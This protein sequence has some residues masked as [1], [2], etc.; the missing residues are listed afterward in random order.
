VPADGRQAPDAAGAS[1]ASPAA[2]AAGPAAGT[3]AGG[4]RPI[5]GPPPA[6]SVQDLSV[7]Y[8]T[9]FERVPTLK[10]AVVRL[11]RGERAV[12]LVHALKNLTFEVPVGT[13]LGIIGANGAGKSTLVR[14]VAGILAPSS[15]RIEVRGR[16]SSLLA[17]GVGFN[18]KLTGRENVMLGGL[19]QGM[20][21]A[22]VIERAEEIAAFADIGEFMDMPLITYSSGMAARLA[23]SVGVH[24]DPDILMIDEAL[25]AGDAQFRVKAAEKMDQLMDSARAMFLVSHSLGTITEMCNDCI[26]MHKGKLMKHGDPQACVDAYTKFL[27]VGENAFTMEDM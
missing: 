3:A 4:A 22:Q 23:F 15:G 11:G 8:R 13:S 7:T 17:L 9:T 2:D 10:S 24:M 1:A 19:A 26:W 5:A 6:V 27:K 20:T 21:R 16:I 12:R 14:A 25:S 18:S